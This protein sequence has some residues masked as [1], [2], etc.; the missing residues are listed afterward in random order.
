[1]F[2]A[3]YGRNASR[4]PRSALTATPDA[5]ASLDSYNWAVPVEPGTFYS[6]YFRSALLVVGLP[7]S[8]PAD[9]ETQA[10]RGVRL[11]DLRH[12]FAVISLSA[13]AH[14][15]AVSTWLGTSRS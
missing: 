3:R 6:N 1:M 15:M 11:H 7:A 9:G 12:S 14:Y 2:P 4:V 10:V 8:A 5:P 13:G